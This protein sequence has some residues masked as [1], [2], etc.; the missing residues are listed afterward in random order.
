MNDDKNDTR[1]HLIASVIAIVVLTVCLCLTTYSLGT[2]S[3]FE[4]AVA[5]RLEAE[6]TLHNGFLKAYD[7]WTR[8]AEQDE[9][10]AKENPFFFHVQRHNGNFLVDYPDAAASLSEGSERKRGPG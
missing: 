8:H 6:E 3:S 7:N 5:V 9:Q 2:F 4:E 10:W 1:K